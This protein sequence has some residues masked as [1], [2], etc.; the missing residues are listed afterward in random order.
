[1]DVKKLLEFMPEFQKQFVSRYEILNYIKA[2]GKVGRRMIAVRLKVSERL[3]RDETTRL[4]DLGLVDVSGKG[5]SVTPKGEEV[6]R[7]FFPIYGELNS[8]AELSDRLSTILQLKKVVVVSDGQG[9]FKPIG[10]A[11][12]NLLTDLLHDGELIGVTGGKTMLAV[13][14]EIFSANYTDVKVIPARG[15]IGTNAN[16]Q[17]DRVASIIATRLNAKYYN[18]PIPETLS[19]ESVELLLQARE[20]KEV[21]RM[22]QQLNLLIFGIGR[23]DVM[24][25]RRGLSEEQKQALFQE[26]VVGEAFGH[27]FTG[28][29]RGISCQDSIGIH[30]EEFQRIPTVIGVAGGREKAQAVMAVAQVRKDMIFVLDEAVAREIAALAK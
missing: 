15:S 23:A 19:K 3:V 13:A 25:Q 27:Y 22:L 30:L 7:E 12:A 10:M 17:A 2:Q 18:Y 4:K 20:V 6:L 21:H 24:T 29:G 26:G 14:Q 28:D 5:I 9:E 1:M 16:F 11:V 8:L